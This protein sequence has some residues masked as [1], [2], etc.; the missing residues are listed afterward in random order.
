LSLQPLAA[1]EH[2]RSQWQLP[3]NSQQK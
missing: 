3:D 2:F 1:S